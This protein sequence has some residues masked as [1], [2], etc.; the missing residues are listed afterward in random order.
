VR[1][2]LWTGLKKLWDTYRQLKAFR[3][4]L[5]GLTLWKYILVGVSMVGGAALTVWSWLL[6]LPGPYAILIGLVTVLLAMAIAS[7]ALR[8]RSQWV[9]RADGEV[10][11]PATARPPGW[12]LALV[13][14][15]L[16]L[17]SIGWLVRRRSK[18]ITPDEV[19]RIEVKLA[20]V[21]DI[22]YRRL[23]ASIIA[24]F[25]PSADI[26]EGPLLHSPDGRRTV[27]ISIRSS[28][29]GRPTLTAIDIL[30]LPIGRKADIEAIDAADSK[31]SDINANAMLLCSNTGFEI[32]AIRKAKRKQ[33]G[34]ISI[35]REGDKRIKAIIEEELYLRKVQM[36]PMNIS[37][38]SVK[39]L[40]GPPPVAHELKYGDGSVDAWLEEKAVQIVFQ[41]PNL[42]RRITATFNL[43]RPVEFKRGTNQVMLQS[44]AIT[45]Q[46]RVQW[47]S[48]IVRLD[49]KAGIYDYV[50][51]RVRLAPGS[52]SYTIQGV[53]FDK[54]TPAEPPTFIQD[55]NIGL[56]AGELDISLMLVEG[57]DLPN[58]LQT[59]P[60][61]ELVRPEDLDL[62]INP[63]PKQP[64]RA[65]PSR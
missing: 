42:T 17:G 9:Y 1:K 24:A 21:P 49:A 20:N 57:M 46:P 27:D 48:Q 15:V 45:F 51:G 16:L 31:R 47:L 23:V 29:S 36:G 25:D 19:S 54:A 58:N 44:I 41:N 11:R 59:A 5:E 22:A 6:H 60:L 4:L 10:S 38:S 37:Y 55:A 2:R 32:E 39:P 13:L 26:A 34:L 18:S 28:R 30:Y 50:R 62:T 43:K 3:D 52:N 14:T 8:L 64:R 61:D 56:E 65:G 40:E 7:Q 63:S 12:I 33:I 35:L 53:D